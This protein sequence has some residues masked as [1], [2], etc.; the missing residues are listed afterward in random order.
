[1]IHN[2]IDGLALGVAFATGNPTEIIP[3]LVAIIAHEIP[4]ELGDVA[5]LLRSS[6]T[7]VQTMLCNGVV[8]FVSLIGVFI[9][10]AVVNLSEVAKT[11]I[12]VFVAGNFIYIASDIWQHIL[13]NKGEGSKRGNALEIFGLSVGIGSMFALTLLEH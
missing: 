6:F 8:N 5:I 9:G 1:M 11:Y 10:L 3:V 4:R 13:K 12:M 2:F 7:E